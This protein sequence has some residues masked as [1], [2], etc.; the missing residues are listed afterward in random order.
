MNDLY[1]GNLVYLPPNYGSMG[2]DFQRELSK[3]YQQALSTACTVAQ[4]QLSLAYQMGNYDPMTH[5]I[6]A[7]LLEARLKQN[8]AKHKIQDL[9]MR[10]PRG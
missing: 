3:G 10:R 4:R 7:K 8:Q 1:P 6:D 9:M 2:F 5:D